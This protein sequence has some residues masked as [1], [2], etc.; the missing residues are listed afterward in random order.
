MRN[1]EWLVFFDAV[2]PAWF[3]ERIATFEPLVTPIY[4]D[5]PAT[6]EVIARKVGGNGS[7]ILAIS[8]Y[9]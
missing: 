3:K 7:R 6:D 2:S 4:I 9:H 1:S 5:G 8:D